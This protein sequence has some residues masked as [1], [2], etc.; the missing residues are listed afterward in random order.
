MHHYTFGVPGWAKV[1]KKL[2][3]TTDMDS[4]MTEDYDADMESSLIEP[5]FPQRYGFTYHETGMLVLPFRYGMPAVCFP[6]CMNVRFY[7]L[8]MSTR[9]WSMLTEQ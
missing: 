9:L 3:F 6:I 7:T 8:A 1:G 5:G 4:T 2:P